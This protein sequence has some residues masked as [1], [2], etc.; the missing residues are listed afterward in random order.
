MWEAARRDDLPELVRLLDA[1]TAPD[2]VPPLRPTRKEQFKAFAAEYGF[3]PEQLDEHRELIEQEMDAA[4]ANGTWG[5]PEPAPESALCVAIRRAAFPMIMKLLSAGADPNRS[6][7]KAGRTPFHDVVDSAAEGTEHSVLQPIVFSLVM[8]GGVPMQIP[9]VDS[10][11][12]KSSALPLTPL[13]YAREHGQPELAEV[14]VAAATRSTREE[15][16][17]EVQRRQQVDNFATAQAATQTFQARTAVLSPNRV[18]Q[19]GRRLAGGQLPTPVYKV[20]HEP[21]FTP[22]GLEHAKRNGSPVRA[23]STLLG[24]FDDARNS[25]VMNLGDDTL[26]M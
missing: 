20:G 24:T 14:M 10:L 25:P 4:L 18:E 17:T 2:P 5:A 6:H 21:T 7:G 9:H 16:N 23:V 11:W 26:K 22:F 19:V 15:R 3:G 1:G 8:A 13:Q 12:L